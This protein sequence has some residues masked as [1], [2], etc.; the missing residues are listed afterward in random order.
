M[1]D[2]CPLCKGDGGVWIDPNDPSVMP[3]RKVR[4]PICNSKVD[5]MEAAFEKWWQP[6]GVRQ[7]LQLHNK[8]FGMLCWKAAYKAGKESQI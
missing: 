7:Y 1:N 4:C 5:D 3:I 6:E 2:K 8:T